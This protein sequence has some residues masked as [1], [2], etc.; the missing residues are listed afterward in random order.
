MPR[1]HN[2]VA[3][4]QRCDHYIAVIDTQTCSECRKLICPDCSVPTSDPDICVCSQ[5]C[6]AVFEKHLKEAA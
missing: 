2:S 1:L 6:R 3:Y 5:D 4:C